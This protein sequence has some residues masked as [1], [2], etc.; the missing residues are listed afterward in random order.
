MRI[1]GCLAAMPADGLCADV[2]R[3]DPPVAGTIAAFWVLFLAAGAPG[4]VSHT[5]LSARPPA[6]RGDPPARPPQPEGD[7]IT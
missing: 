4:Q 1:D 5:P 2:C 3:Q 7:P 6:G